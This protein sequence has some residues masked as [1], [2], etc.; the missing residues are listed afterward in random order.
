MGD[1]IGDGVGP[2]ERECVGR[3][4]DVVG[5]IIDLPTC[6]EETDG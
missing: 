2:L 4:H 5:F 6:A 3:I 1:E